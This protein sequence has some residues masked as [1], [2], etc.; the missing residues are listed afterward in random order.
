MLL[1]KIP[2]LATYAL[3]VPGSLKLSLKINITRD[4][5]S[6]FVNNLTSD[7]INRI[8]ENGEPNLF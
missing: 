8:K 7:L 3:T 1:I 6:W 5:D 2:S 4:T